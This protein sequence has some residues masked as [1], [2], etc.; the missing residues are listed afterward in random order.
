MMFRTTSSAN[1][2]HS[3]P[4]CQSAIHPRRPSHPDLDPAGCCSFLPTCSEDT[5]DILRGYER[6]SYRQE[7]EDSMDPV[8]CAQ[9]QSAGA[10]RDTV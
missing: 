1:R 2:S 5:L 4:S 7:L 3:V 10:M 6:P 8:S 9:V